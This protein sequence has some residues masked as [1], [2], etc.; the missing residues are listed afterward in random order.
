M[1]QF[2]RDDYL[3]LDGLTF[4]FRGPRGDSCRAGLQ[5][6]IARRGNFAGMMDEGGAGLGRGN[7]ESCRIAEPFRGRVR[8]R[9]RR[10]RCALCSSIGDQLV[11]P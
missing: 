8:L 11:R 2:Y 1:A 10:E 9:P 7:R 4:G 5:S 6:I 3:V